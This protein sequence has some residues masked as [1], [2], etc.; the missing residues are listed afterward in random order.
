M[1]EV[2]L[3]KGAHFSYTAELKEDNTLFLRRLDEEDHIV[4][5]ITL[6]DFETIALFKFLKAYLKVK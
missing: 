1:V 6:L 2:I 3:N 4:A 5:Q